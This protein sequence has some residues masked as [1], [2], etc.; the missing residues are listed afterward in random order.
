MRKGNVSGTV[1]L[2]IIRVLAAFQ[3]VLYFVPIIRF[4][5]SIEEA[6][7]FLSGLF[8]WGGGSSERQFTISL[9]DMTFGQSNGRGMSSMQPRYFC[10]IF[11]II[12][13]AILIFS[14]FM[15]SEGA[16]GFAVLVCVIENSLALFTDKLRLEDGGMVLHYTNWFYAVIATNAL[17]AIFALVAFINSNMR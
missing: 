5:T 1:I 14:F 12:P 15:K 6:G 13:V 16:F 4:K 8:G 10:I 17:L 3:G 11:I 9:M 2:N 7:G